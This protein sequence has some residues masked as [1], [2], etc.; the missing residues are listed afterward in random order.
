MPTAHLTDHV[1]DRLA[2]KGISVEAVDLVCTAYSEYEYDEIN[3]SF[4]LQGMVAGG[5]LAVCVTA[6]S[7]Y[8][9]RKVVKTAYWLQRFGERV[10]AEVLN[11]DVHLD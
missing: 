4:K 9:A 10:R 8:L 3:N 2:Q 6:R 5:L 11:D 7:F 1:R